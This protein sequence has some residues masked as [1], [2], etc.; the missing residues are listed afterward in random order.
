MNTRYFLLDTVFSQHELAVA[1]DACKSS[2][3]KDTLRVSK[4]VSKE[5]QKEQRKRR[6]IQKIQEEERKVRAEGGPSYE[7]GGSFD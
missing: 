4:S 3:R 6:K 2:K 5:L 1:S 7:A